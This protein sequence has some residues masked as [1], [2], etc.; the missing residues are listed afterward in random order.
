MRFNLN[1]DSSLMVYRGRGVYTSPAPLQVY[2]EYI[3]RGINFLNYLDNKEPETVVES[4]IEP[5]T[6][7]KWT[8]DWWEY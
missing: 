5:V 8:K 2:I 7:N 6:L 4:T 3:Y 1:V